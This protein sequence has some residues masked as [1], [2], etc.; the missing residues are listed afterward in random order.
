MEP[1]GNAE[2]LKI[3]A[4]QDNSRILDRIVRDGARKMLQVALE[5]EVNSFLEINSSKVDK[6]SRRHVVR[7]GYRPSR[8]VIT[9]AGSLVVEQPRVRDRSPN[10]GRRVKFSSSIT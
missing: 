3:A 6:T 10:A 1:V 5:D 7:N 8:E 2:V 4:V 9:G